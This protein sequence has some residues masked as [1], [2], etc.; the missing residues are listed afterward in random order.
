MRIIHFAD[1]HLGYRAYT[2]V[3]DSGINQREADVFK[4]FETAL[5][6]MAALKPDLV[7]MAG[8]LFHTVRP[9]NLIIHQTFRRLQEFVSETGCPI[10]MIAGNHESPRSSD[11]GCILRLYT[12]ISGVQVEDAR[13]VSRRIPNT[14]VTV[15]CVPHRGLGYL[16]N[17]PLE[18]DP[19]SRHNILMIHGTLDG[20]TPSV[21]D[22]Y[23]VPRSV[24]RAQQWDYI[25]CGH[26]HRFEQVTANGY[27]S[28]SLEYTSPNFWQ[29][30]DSAKGFIE[31]DLA[32]RRL[33]KFHKVQSPRPFAN[34]GTI[35]ARGLSPTEVDDRIQ[36]ALAKVRG[37]IDDKVIRLVI[38]NIPREVQR[39][40]DYKAIREA[41]AT[42]LHFDLV[43]LQPG[44]V[45]ESADGR[46][47]DGL[48]RRTLETEWEE[49]A[50]TYELPPAVQRA[51]LKQLGLEYLSKAD[52]GLGAVS[53]A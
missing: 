35:D 4:T 17:T 18:P 50:D 7:L 10:L 3:T 19:H 23:I 42:A 31:Y 6:S 25:A 28:G 41:K 51:R 30:L 33:V 1:V 52:D 22:T 32:E 45:R 27:Y 38:E 12:N 24:I 11:T 21:Y 15:F 14:D 26:Y 16:E 37:G 39:E 8:D 48:H 2:R 47:P 43:L 20:I 46:R 9:S 36:T 34:L 44:K 29:E 13:C 53:D 5:N 40:L 49:F